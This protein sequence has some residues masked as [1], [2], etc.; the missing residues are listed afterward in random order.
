M[1][2]RKRKIEDSIVKLTGEKEL[3]RNNRKGKKVARDTKL[4][5]RKK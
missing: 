1:R 2:R 5:K 3:K 4:S